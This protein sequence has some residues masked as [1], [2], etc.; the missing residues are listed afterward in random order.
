VKK[1]PHLA[2]IQATFSRFSRFS[3]NLVDFYI[4]VN[5]VSRSVFKIQDN[6]SRIKP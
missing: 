2:K 6:D 4:Q 3:I 5:V 1:K